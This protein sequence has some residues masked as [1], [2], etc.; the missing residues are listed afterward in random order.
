MC[1]AFSG[2]IREAFTND[3]NVR[4]YILDFLIPRFYAQSYYRKK[5]SWP[6]GEHSHDPVVSFFEWLSE[7]DFN[8]ARKAIAIDHLAHFADNN[9]LRHQFAKSMSCYGRY[10][11]KCPLP[12]HG[13][14]KKT[15][16]D[17]VKHSHMMNGIENMR[18]LQGRSNPYQFLER[19]RRVNTGNPT[20][21]PFKKPSR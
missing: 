5:K 19:H 15:F 14:S 13:N 10:D 4:G 17:C 3:F 7:K 12:H 11:K 20:S 18:K 2:K 1:V 16:H 9:D 8:D 6:W 21:H